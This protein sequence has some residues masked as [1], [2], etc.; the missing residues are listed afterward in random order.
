MCK[1]YSNCPGDNS[2]C[3]D[4]PHIPKKVNIMDNPNFKQEDKYLVLKLH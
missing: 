2:E 1:C 3:S 4:C